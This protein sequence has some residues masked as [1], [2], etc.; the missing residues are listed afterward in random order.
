MFTVQQSLEK[1]MFH[2]LFHYVALFT[3][4]LK[5]HRSNLEKHQIQFLDRT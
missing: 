2:Q 1:L 4:I 3:M 5:P